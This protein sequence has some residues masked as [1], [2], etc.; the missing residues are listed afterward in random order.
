[1][2]I[3]I[4]K[5]FQHSPHFESLRWIAGA[6]SV[7]VSSAVM[8]FTK[9]IHPPAGATV[10]L[11]STT[12][13]ITALGWL[14]LP[15]VIMGSLLLVAVAC[16]VNNIQRQFPVY[17]WTSADLG[18]KKEVD[19]EKTPSGKEEAT[20]RSSNETHTFDAKNRIEI[21]EVGIMVPDWLNLAPEE[22]VL[23]NCLRT[24]LRNGYCL[25]I[26]RSKESDMTQVE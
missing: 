26:S 6:L 16:V 5:L 1:V 23:L 10:L 7:G 8:G 4:T 13:A 3:S 11:C 12:P 9:T 20:E 19:L 21:D 18:P 15:L 22:Q 25:E 14:L 2:G 24:R 17:W